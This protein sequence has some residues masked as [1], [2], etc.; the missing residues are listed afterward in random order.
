M[1]NKSIVFMV[2]SALLVASIYS[3]STF[4]VFAAPPYNGYV[5]RCDQT[6]YN[7]G[8]IASQRCCTKT[9][10]KGK[11][12]SNLCDPW[13]CYARDGSEK[14]CK[15]TLTSGQ[16]GNPITTSGGALQGNGT[17]NS[18]GNPITTSGGAL[19]GNGTTNSNNNTMPLRL[20]A[21]SSTNPNSVLKD[22]SHFE[23]GGIM[24]PPL[25]G[26]Q[27]GGPI[28][29]APPVSNVVVAVTFNSITVHDKHEGALSGDGEYDLAAYV[30]GRKVGLTDASVGGGLSDV[31]NGDTINFKPGSQII[32]ELPNTVPISIFTV[33]TEVDDCGRTPFPHNIQQMLPIFFDPQLDWL[34]AISNLQSSM[35]SYSQ[36]GEISPS[37]GGKDKGC[38]ATSL[39]NIKNIIIPYDANDILGTIREF[40]DPPG[41]GIGPHVVK[42][43]TGDFTLRYTISTGNACNASI[44]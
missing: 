20:N 34:S 3:L 38:F 14:K 42:S 13:T 30:Q 12:V 43:S 25:K 10:V 1:R 31:G 11:L 41:Y 35:N 9:Y 29:A 6:F 7:N 8:H 32:T 37:Q 22:G 2:I 40:Y 16:P 24:T 44:C 39:K 28:N 18:T 21:T 19:Q 33:G 26:L 15:N 23:D 17:T 27:K 5:S 4:I 36:L